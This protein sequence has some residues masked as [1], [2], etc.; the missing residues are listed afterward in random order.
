M[1]V[2]KENRN[3][4]NEIGKYKNNNKNVYIYTLKLIRIL[5]LGIKRYELEHLKSKKLKMIDKKIRQM[6]ICFISAN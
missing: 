4:K 6:T 2:I 5:M 3:E 1:K